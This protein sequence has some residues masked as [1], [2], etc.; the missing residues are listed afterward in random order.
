MIH[1]ELSAGISAGAGNALSAARRVANSV[2]STIRS[3][4]KIHSPSRVMMSI[5]GFVSEGLAKGILSAGK[6]VDK[7]SSKLAVLATPQLNAF[8]APQMELAGVTRNITDVYA[9]QGDYDWDDTQ[10][11]SIDSSEIDAMDASLS[12]PV[13]IKNK[14][15]TPE[16][17]L[18]IEGKD[19]EDIDTDEIIRRIEEIIIDANNDDLG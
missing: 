3:A 1:F 11:V 6:L 15:I 7:A 14:Q 5:G 4:L 19:A 10:R 18:T 12:R 2:S 8:T 16:I 9:G 17:N 13:I